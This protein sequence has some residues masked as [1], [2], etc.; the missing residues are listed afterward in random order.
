M[1]EIILHYLWLHKRIFATQ[2]KTTKGEELQILNF[3]FYQQNSGPDF[4]NA[5]LIIAHQK[6]AGNIEMHVKSSDWYLHHHETDSAYDNVIL[7]VVW[8][9]DV[10]V[11]RKDTT[12]IPVLELK[13]FVAP[14]LIYSIKKLVEQNK[15]INCEDFIAKTDD[16]KFLKWKEQLFV[17][18]LQN[19]QQFVNQVFE[20][21]DRNWEATTF[22]LLAKNFGLNYNGDNFKEMMRSIPYAVLQ[23]E[24]FEKENLEALFFGVSGLLSVTVDDFY[25]EKLN[26]IWQYQKIKYQLTENPSV[27][28]QFYKLRP[29]NFPT[30]RLAQ[31]A[32]LFSKFSNLFEQIIE[33]KSVENA[34]K[35]FFVD[36]S[37]YWKTHYNWEKTRK[38][39]NSN[40]SRSFIELLLINTVI[41]LQFSYSNYLGTNDIEK[42]IAF[43]TKLK[44]EHNTIIN[45]FKAIGITSKNAF[46]SQ[47]LLQLKNEYCTKK[48][49]LRCVV[50]IQFLKN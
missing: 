44:S 46:D 20:K 18:R 49:C 29:D 36:I 4:F 26:T 21:A 50:G 8:E 34:S 17:E 7:H 43:Q 42:I 14:E 48:Q 35:L 6:W 38:T 9:H 47:S 24:R 22:I 41:P 12:E 13:N 39:K 40:L 2:L 27:K 37:N 45:N 10:E 5:Q 30:I 19:K 11:Y 3:G 33:L 28:P 23:K 32:A 25:F 15:W 16:F 31:L 1:K